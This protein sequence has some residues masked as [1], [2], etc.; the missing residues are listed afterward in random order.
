LALPTTAPKPLRLLV[1]LP[2]W[3]GDVVMATPALRLLRENL[4]GSFIGALCRPGLDEILEGS[5][6]FDEMH[7]ERGGGVFG[8]KF[9]AAKVRPRRY[10]AALLLTNSFST[11]LV[12]RIAGIPRRLGYNRDGRGFLLTD[13]LI[14]PQRGDG[15][16]AII[17]ACRYYYDAAESLLHHEQPRY[18]ALSNTPIPLAFAP[19]VK[20]ELACSPRQV[21]SGQRLL[22]LAGLAPGTP[23][24][25]LN[26]GGNNP[27][28]RWP[29]Q[30]FAA[31]AD[32]LHQKY[33]LISLING[34]PAEVQVVQE[35]VRCCRVASP[36]ALP[37]LTPMTPITPVTPATPLTSPSP[38]LTLSTLK[39]IVSRAKI[40]ITNDTG[41]RHI[42]AALGVPIVT[43]F[44]PTDHRWTLIPTTA[45]DEIITADPL[46]PDYLSANDH[47]ER[48]AIVNITTERVTEA[49]NRVLGQA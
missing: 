46:L 47:P 42:A 30:R 14:T 35:V 6:F 22:T 43:L 25:V 24:A 3:V 15:A 4:K 39:Y 5:D 32:Y 17:P 26:P 41:P 21:E 11:A 33:N 45:P 27:A 8:P 29:P 13:K 20:L 16:W 49:I 37:L 44:G 19:N 40:M 1:I 38:L 9:M 23:F 7:I 28:K 10:E 34:S 36:V 48:C 31:V 18:N 2:N 12:A